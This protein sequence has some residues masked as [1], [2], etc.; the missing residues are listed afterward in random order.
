MKIENV[1]LSL[2]LALALTAI[3]ACTKQSESSAY[4]G[5]RELVCTTHGRVTMRS[6]QVGY[7]RPPAE[8]GDKDDTYRFYRTYNDR[9]RGAVG[10][11]RQRM[12]EY[13]VIYRVNPNPPNF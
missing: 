1:F 6:Q 12:G 13:C 4:R 3:P 2:A 7:I 8:F 11:Y 9:H 10:R 5:M